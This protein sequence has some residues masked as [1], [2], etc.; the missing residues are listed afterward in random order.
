MTFKWVGRRD[1]TMRIIR[2]C[3][4][5]WKHGIV[6]DGDGYSCKLTLALATHIFA[7]R[8]EWNAWFLYLLGFRLHYNRSYGGIHDR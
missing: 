8:R 6:G 7:F 1:P 3:R 5:T 4:I 2:L